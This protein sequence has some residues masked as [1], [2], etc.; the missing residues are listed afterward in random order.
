[1][2][3]RLIL[4]CFILSFN[5]SAIGLDDVFGRLLGKEDSD[6]KQRS[7]YVGSLSPLPMDKDKPTHIV[8]AGSAMD[9][10]SDQFFQSALLKAK[11]YREL[12]PS[13]QVILV[14]EPDVIKTSGSEVFNRFNVK[15]V[16]TESGQLIQK[17]LYR[18]MDKFNQ[19][20]SFDFYGHS[21]PWGLRL[22]FSKA[23]LY[24]V[25]A[26]GNLKAKFMPTA[27]ANL[28]GC[29][30]GFIIAPELSKLWGIPVSGNLTGSVFEGLQAD[31][32]WYKKIDRTSSERVSENRVNFEESKHCYEGV[33]WR[34]KAQRHN[35]SS[36]WGNFKDGGLSFP[37]FFCDFEDRSKC[38]KAMAISLITHPSVN[39]NKLKPSYEEYEAKVMD[40]LCST[41]SDGSYFDKCRDGILR[42]VSSGDLKFQMHPGN[43]LNCNLKSCDVEV[44]CQSGNTNDGFKP[45]SCYLK[46]TPNQN[47]TTLVREFLLYKEAYSLLP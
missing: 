29:N 35:Y 31:D 5:A 18:L 24:P 19:I 41:H 13:H 33:C 34:M 7:F 47:P 8:V 28:N 27:Y 15:V 43:A 32:Y 46:T 10:D 2:E 20:A 17:Q 16:A 42:A 39:L 44:K 4:L 12:Y 21:S 9:V 11:I 36:Y 38:L 6:K 23:S 22:G 37:K 45:G 30:T 25:S 40:I 26:W 3:L 1:M 14:S